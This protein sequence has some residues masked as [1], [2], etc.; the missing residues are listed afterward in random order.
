MQGEEI[1]IVL[2]REEIW[3][4]GDLTA[5][6]K[7]VR[8][9]DGADRRLQEERVGER[10]KVAESGCGGRSPGCAGRAELTVTSFLAGGKTTK[11]ETGA[12]RLGDGSLYSSCPTEVLSG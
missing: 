3:L 9:A 8:G 5:A 6:F 7:P 12:D 4:Q 10:W 1:A 2:P 11:N